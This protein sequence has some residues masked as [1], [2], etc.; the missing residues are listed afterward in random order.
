MRAWIVG[1]V[2]LALAACGEPPPC[3]VDNEGNDVPW[4]EVTFAGTS[5]PIDFCP[6]EHWAAD[7]D[8]NTCGCSQTG[9]VVCTAL[10]CGG[11]TDTNTGTSPTDTGPTDT[12]ATK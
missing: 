8:C 6:L 3:G 7:D 9:Q 2:L 11:T 12:G 4:C 10:Q 1:T 5:E